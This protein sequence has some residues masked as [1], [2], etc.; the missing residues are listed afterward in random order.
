MFIC[1]KNWNV[2]LTEMHLGR[3]VFTP[4]AERGTGSSKAPPRSPMPAF[5]GQPR[6]SLHRGV[7]QTQS[8][9]G[10]G[11]RFL[12]FFFNFFL[13]FFF[14]REHPRNQA[15]PWLATGCG[16]PHRGT[17]MRAPRVPGCPGA[18][19]S[20]ASVPGASAPPAAALPRLLLPAFG[21]T[22]RG[23]GAVAPRRPVGTRRWRRASGF[24]GS[25]RR[26]R[27]ADRL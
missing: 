13:Y 10:A 12:L 20:P 4:A 14:L 17:V 1:E 27:Q 15:S 5:S 22:P 18:P 8:P 6:M 16:G 24:A 21:G 3:L 19:R 9:G 7:A 26:K 23:N 25:R 2:S 11:T